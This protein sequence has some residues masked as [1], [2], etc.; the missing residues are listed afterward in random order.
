MDDPPGLDRSSDTVW[1]PVKMVRGDLTIVRVWW[2]CLRGTYMYVPEYQSL[3]RLQRQPMGIPV[4]TALVSDSCLFFFFF[5]FFFFLPRHSIVISTYLVRLFP[6]P[7]LQ[8]WYQATSWLASNRSGGVNW[9]TYSGPE[10]AISA[11]WLPVGS[12]RPARYEPSQALQLPKPS[13]CHFW[14]L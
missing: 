10:C 8:H 1:R 13:C 7:L 3:R 6:S 5:F 11:H 4:T 12:A 9:P 2:G 14:Y